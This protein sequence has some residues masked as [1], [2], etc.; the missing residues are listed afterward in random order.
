[1]PF[2]TNVTEIKDQVPETLYIS[3]H[4]N[5]EPG[6]TLTFTNNEKLASQ[7]LQY[8]TYYYCL[9]LQNF[10]YFTIPEKS[11]RSFYVAEYTF[12]A[13]QAIAQY[14]KLLH[15][16]RLLELITNLLPILQN[17]NTSTKVQ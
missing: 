3:Y 2:V 14:V 9:S 10:P 16:S 12:Q 13:T 4:Q 1:M 11:I 7:S 6:F 15:K 17:P 5:K 8:N